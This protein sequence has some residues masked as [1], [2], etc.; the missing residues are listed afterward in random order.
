MHAY[1]KPN[2]NNMGKYLDLSLKLKKFIL[3]KFKRIK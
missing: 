1:D 3:I 2:S